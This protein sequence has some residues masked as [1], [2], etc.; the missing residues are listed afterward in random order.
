MAELMVAELALMLVELTAALK[1][2]RMVA[3]TA[4][5]RV[6]KWADMKVGKKVDRRVA[7]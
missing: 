2:T 5:M 3:L 6:D 7:L 1:D 4:V